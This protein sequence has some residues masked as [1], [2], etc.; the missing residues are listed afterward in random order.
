[1]SQLG[2]TDHGVGDKLWCCK[3]EDVT[4]KYNATIHSAHNECLDTLWYGRQPCAWEFRVFG[5][6][7]EAKIGTHLAQLDPRSENGYFLG[8]TATKAVI[9]YFKPEEPNTI[10]YCVTAKFYE[11]ITYLPNGQLSPGSALTQ[12]TRNHLPQHPPPSIL[13][14]TPSSIHRHISSL[15][16]CLPKTHVLE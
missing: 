1:M 4:Q 12:G 16:L 10:H 11:Y 2:Q 6:K 14:T 13:R 3:C 8:T 9:R 15:W 7:V 5:C